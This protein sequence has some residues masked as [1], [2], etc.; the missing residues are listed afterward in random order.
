MIRIISAKGDSTPMSTEQRD[1]AQRRARQ[2]SYDAPFDTRVTPE[3]PKAPDVRLAEAAEYAAAQLWHI[4]RALD[5]LIAAV[6][7]RAE[8]EPPA[9]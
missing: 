8:N 7:R 5:H 2:E 1:A 4:R 6:A 3:R 9:P